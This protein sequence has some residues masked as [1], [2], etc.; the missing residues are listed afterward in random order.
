MAEEL[1]PRVSWVI[2]AY[3]AEEFIEECILSV[4]RQTYT[5]FEVIVVDDGSTDQTPNLLARLAATDQRISVFS[6]SNQGLTKALI[7]G[8]NRARGEFIARIDADDIAE[9]QRL[10]RQVSFL[11]ANPEYVC[12]GSE[13]RM[14]T[15]D[16]LSLGSKE[17]L[18][19]H[20]AIRRALLLGI[21]GALSHPSVLFRRSVYEA[22]GGYDSRY[23]IAQDLDLFLKFSEAGRVENLPEVL[24]HWRQHEASIN[25][26]RWNEWIGIKRL[27]IAETIRRVGP[28]A[29]AEGLFFQEEPDLNL[30]DFYQ[31]AVYAYRRGQYSTAMHY[32]RRGFRAK[33]GRRALSKLYLKSLFFRSRDRLLGLLRFGRQTPLPA[34]PHS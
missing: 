2:S 8:C 5:N 15:P 34:V 7:N 13:V 29:F 11:E 17:L 27:A 1:K 16:G 31:V 18:R 21:G 32:A 28:E 3:N 24:L 22:V 25:R 30:S 4:L 33:Q 12:I 14:L 20:E 9:P 19:G 23:K 10:E 6:Q 26:T